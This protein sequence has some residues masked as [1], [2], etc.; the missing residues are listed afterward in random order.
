MSDEAIEYKHNYK[1]VFLYFIRLG[2]LGFGG[3][4]ALVGTMQAELVEGRKWMDVNDF[5]ASFSL[6]KAMPGP[7]AFQTAVFLGRTRAGFWGGFLAGFGIVFPAF[8]MMILFSMFFSSI[9]QLAFTQ[10][11][12][13][14]MQVAAL[15]VILGSLKSLV[16]YNYKDIFFWVLVLI[17]GY[18]NYFH[19]SLEPVVIIGFGILIVFQ[20]RYKRRFL[21]VAP[22]LLFS[23]SVKNLALVC[24]KAGALVFGTGLAIVPM[25]QH[26]VVVKYHWLTQSEFLN[27][28]A[29]GQMTPGPV[30]VTATYVGHKIAGMTG[31]IVGTVCIF[32]AAFFHMSTWFPHVVKKLRGKIWINDFVFGAVAGV[33]GPIIVTVVKMGLGIE[34]NFFLVSMA[35]IIFILTLFNKVPLWL[36]IPMGGVLNFLAIKMF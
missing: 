18:I 2:C 3:P 22:L 26:D 12:M 20:G 1:E 17:S 7:V 9:S 5:N 36:L 27:A 14:G 35:I 34:L 32:A 25:L 24:F 28:L 33:V 13:L 29:F 21:S 23:S 15:G 6:I 8:L 30:V 11:L 31:A 10:S 16:K 4:L 19:P